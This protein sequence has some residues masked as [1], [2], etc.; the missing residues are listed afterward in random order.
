MGTEITLNIGGITLTYSKNH[1]GVDHGSLFHEKDRKRLK[2][3][4]IDYD[5]FKETGEDSSEMEMAERLKAF[6]C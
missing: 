6:P 4:R 3:D 5:Y 1:L 2:S